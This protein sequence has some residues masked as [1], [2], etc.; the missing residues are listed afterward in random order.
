MTALVP[1]ASALV[2]YLRWTPR[3]ERVAAR[4]DDPDAT[5]HISHLSVLEVTSALRGL[6]L[7]KAV[8]LRRA[9][10]ALT[11]LLNLAATRHDV[12]PFLDT[13]WSLRHNHTI[14]DASYVALAEALEA[15]LITCDA[16]FD[17]PSV[18]RL[19]TVEVIR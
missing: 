16:K 13:I 8:T 10:D 12:E 6:V 18:R 11:D 7:G 3:G 19:I 14:Y 1:D 5:V 4:I 17:T 9:E 2:E 15:P